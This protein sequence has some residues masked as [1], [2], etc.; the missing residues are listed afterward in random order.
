VK[1]N[2][3][4]RV[5][6]LGIVSLLAPSAALADEPYF[7]G[8]GDLPGGDYWSEVLDISADGTTVVGSSEAEAGLE[9][10]KWTNPATG[11]AGMIGLGDL[12]GGPFLSIAWGVNADGSVVVG[13]SYVDDTYTEAF[14]WTDPN[15]GGAGMVSIGDLPGG[16]TRGAGLAASADGSVI[17][18][19]GTSEDDGQL[20]AFR[21]TDPNQGGSGMVGLGFL[22]GGYF[23]RG[24]AITPDGSMIAGRGSSD[25]ALIE[26]F[27]WSDPN[28]GGEGMIGL[29]VLSHRDP[30]SNATDITA[31]GTVIVGGSRTMS[32]VEA[33]MWTDPAVGGHGMVGLGL[34][35]YYPESECL[36]VSADG[37]VVVGSASGEGMRRAMY[38]TDPHDG[39][40]GMVLLHDLLVSEYGLD[41]TGWILT[42][43]EGLSADGRTIAGNGINPSGQHEGWIAH[44]GS[45][46]PPCPGDLDGDGY[47]GLEDLAQLLAH[48]GTPSGATY[49]D[50]DID[51]DGDVDLADLATLLSVY[52][53]TCD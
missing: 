20:E 15:T 31:D 17:T 13:S 6:L 1:N 4:N 34:V 36:A 42:D 19:W 24:M 12:P 44:L 37:S 21:W 10:Y 11:G 25:S 26:G 45:D 9:A 48:Y 29:G 32:G 39:G 22:P 47:V 18:G 35:E 40:T 33:Y 7:M 52:G 43:A 41:L 46:S 3:L 5:V 8:L 49:E 28:Q 53:T 38:W 30:V 23:S 14:R 2:V 27:R 16:Q 50:G 51:G